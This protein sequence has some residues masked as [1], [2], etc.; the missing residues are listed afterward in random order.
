MV[1]YVVT[2][3]SRGIG[4]ALV[5][6]LRAR[7]ALRPSNTLQDRSPEPLTFAIVQ[8]QNS[9]DELQQLAGPNCH[10]IL[11]DLDKPETLHVRTALP[12]PSGP[13]L[14]EILVRCRRGC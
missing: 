10:V 3:A 1:S 6:A 13:S 5:Q 11:G 9:C 12:L 7:R 8:D 2:G 14:I 4:L